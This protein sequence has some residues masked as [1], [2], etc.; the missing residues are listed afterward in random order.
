M[1]RRRRNTLPASI[2][3]PPRWR[4]HFGI[5]I[6][7]LA[8]A[9]AVVFERSGWSPVGKSPEVVRP[10]S[11]N[12]DDTARYHDKIFAVVHVVD[13]DTLDID[14]PDPGNGKSKT[15]IRLWGVDCPEI[16]H[17]GNGNMHFGPQ[18]TAFAQEKLT[19]DVQVVLSP[20]RT[21]DKYGRLLA[22]VFME[23]G[24]AMFNEMLIEEGFAYA[25]PRFDHHYETRFAAAERRAREKRAGLWSGVKLADMP[26]WRQKR[27]K[28]QSALKA[29]IGADDQSP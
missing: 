21:R 20:K 25:D 6:T 7:A 18:A 5:L 1:P 27:E 10:D 3:L 24:G 12:P 13:G 16:A 8:I 22:Y 19:G 9:G 26:K 4:R 2:V 29:E 14:A 23:P 28:K 11:L 17:G 15:R